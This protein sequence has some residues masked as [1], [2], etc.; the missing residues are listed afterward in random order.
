MNSEHQSR[1]AAIEGIVGG[2][3]AGA[4]FA[5]ATPGL[6]AA[7]ETDASS[8]FP[9]QVGVATVDITPKEEITL[10][11][12]PSPQK[13][14]VVATPLFAKALVI[15][16]GE[17]KLVI[18]T[19]DTLKYPT[20]LVVKARARIEEEIGIPADRIMI[21][22]SHTHRGPLWTYYDDRL[23][24]P[25][26]R[27]VATAFSQLEP[28]KIGTALGSTEGVSENRRL[29]KGGEVWNRWLLPHSEQG[30]YPTE[31]PAD[32]ALGVLAVIGQDGKYRAL[33]YHFASHPAST[34]DSVIS[35]DYPGHVQRHIDE[36]IGYPVPTLFLL[37]PC[38]DVN[39]SASSEIV[40][41]AIGEGILK[42]LEG[43]E[44][45]RKPGLH[46]LGRELAIPVRQNPEFQE[47]ELAL[48]WPGN[49]EHYR[50][51]FER[52]KKSQQPTYQC[53][54]SGIAIG[55]DFAIVTNPF[56]L[57]CEIGLTIKAGS[58]FRHTMVATLT[59]GAR[60]Y[61][62]TRKAFDGKGYETWFGEHSYLSKEAGEMTGEVS[63]NLL[64]ELGKER[65][66]KRE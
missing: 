57:F 37:G 48:K 12:S 29:I 2:L 13:T 14:S 6:T 43:I 5:G 42:S 35:A 53:L 23:I 56:E 58:P 61:V 28:C 64:E 9:F 39:T 44:L 4:T 7:D 11:G 66:V 33:L 22:A 27:A 63:A 1:R 19:L 40:G 15:S 46:V 65:L 16:T 38:G 50:K 49:V 52:M 41:K 31:G 45:I 47:A 17:Q 8:E 59:N 60:G 32:P 51:A 62:P 18:V 26:C 34:R 30:R 55:D 3:L 20:D 24:D 10:A 21:C 54:F 25:I 36:R